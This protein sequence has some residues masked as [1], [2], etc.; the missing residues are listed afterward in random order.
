[1]ATKAKKRT[2]KKQRRASNPAIDRATAQKTALQPESETAKS[3]TGPV[4]P[5][6]ASALCLWLSFAPAQFSFL[7]W[8][9]PL[10]WLSFATRPT[11]TRRDYYHLWLSG[12]CFWLAT[13]QGIRLA[14]WALYFG[15]FAL[16][17]Y[18]AI[19]TPLFV[20]LTRNLLR[21]R[22]PLFLVAPA[23]WVGLEFA[24]SYVLT[25]FCSNMLAHTQ[26]HWPL[27]IQI[28]D[29]L[30]AYG[31]SF[32]VMLVAVALRD[33]WC[34]FAAPSPTNAWGK[35]GICLAVLGFAGN[36]AYGAYKLGE[37][38]ARTAATE[39]QAL[40]RV[41]L[42]QENAPTIFDAEPNAIMSG[43]HKYLDATRSEAKK[44][45]AIDLIVWPEST[46][47]G[48]VPWI[49]S[50]LP[51]TLPVVDG[52]PLERER[53]VYSLARNE[54][55]QAFRFGQLGSAGRAE[56]EQ[57]ATPHLLLGCDAMVITSERIVRYNSAIWV[58]E[59]GQYRD[60]YDKMHLVMFGE[61]FPL[62]SMLQFLRDMFGT[63]DFGQEPKTFEIN[64]C[65]VAPNICFESMMPRVI[66]SQVAQLDADGKSPDLLI[67]LSNDSWFHGSSMLDHH[68]ACSILCA[69]ENRRPML[70]A[71]NTGIS[72]EIDGAGRVLKSTDKAASVGLLAMPQGDG[73]RGLVQGWGYP[74]AW[75]CMLLVLGSVLS[76]WLPRRSDKAAE[77]ENSQDS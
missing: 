64:G 48:G 31:V 55:E 60:R 16:S 1:M 18:L 25:G 38:P 66:Q 54:Q 20:G 74:L 77:S 62:G 69:V 72:A 15:W 5:A 23:I 21:R 28:A 8:F 6:Y 29:Q 71:A 22:I 53:L 50:N 35:L 24:R 65:R 11:L 58:D 32:L 59:N 3:P 73:R 45:A 30:G 17:V 67:N 47:T 43:W 33:A 37:L 10:G 7:A 61:Y 19:Y 34:S 46:F 52:Q 41:M 63:V 51:D 12:C 76:A 13:L 70:A 57:A 40:L 2:N 9:A 27:M 68:L 36:L 14:F 39:D 4:W 26:A 44:Y 56:N 75:C 49:D 42:V